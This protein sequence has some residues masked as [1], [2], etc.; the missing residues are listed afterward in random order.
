MSIVALITWIITAGFGFFM[1]LRW[2]TRGGC[3]GAWS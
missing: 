1:L 2:A 3:A